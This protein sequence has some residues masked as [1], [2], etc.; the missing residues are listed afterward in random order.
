MGC[1]PG[2]PDL[3]TI[4]AA[5]LIEQA[6]VM[7]YSG[8]LIPNAISDMC[9]GIKHDASGM[10]RQKI[11]D[12]LREAALDGKTTIRLHDGDPTIYGAIREQMDQ[13]EKEGIRCT[14][15]PGVTAMLA[16]AAALGAQLTLPGVTQTIII[17]RVESRTEVPKIESISSLAQ[18]KATMILYLS[19]H[20]LKKIVRQAMEGGYKPETPVAVVYRASQSGQVIVGGT[21]ND[22]EER[23]RKKQIT[24][25]AII[26]IGDV[27]KPQSYEY[28]R[29]YDETFSH[30]YRRATAKRSE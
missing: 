13:L 3:L 7:V 4:K 25:T 14:I 11:T 12:V 15:I 26:I 16:S 19:V 1:G 8:S 18:H 29:L 10:V 5:N 17:T 30:M 23:V 6:D 2:D 27:I 9:R 22:I 20:L 21:L 28:S 24:R